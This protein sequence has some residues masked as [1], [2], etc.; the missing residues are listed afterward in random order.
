L[1]AWYMWAKRHNVPRF[2]NGSV[3]KADI[4]RALRRPDGRKNNGRTFVGR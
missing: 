2:S 4:I 3:D 1:N